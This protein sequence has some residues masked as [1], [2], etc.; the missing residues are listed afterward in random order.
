MN[1]MRGL[2]AVA[3]ALRA[4]DF[5]MDRHAIDYSVG[6]IEV[7][8]GHG[9]FLPVRQLTDQFGNKEFHSAEEVVRAIRDKA[10]PA[11]EAS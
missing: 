11:R 3:E 1:V 7:E 8:D 6:D 2:R 10:R 9:G 5:P 4:E